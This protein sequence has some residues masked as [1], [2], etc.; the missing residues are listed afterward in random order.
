MDGTEREPQVIQA[1]LDMEDAYNQRVEHMA[2]AIYSAYGTLVDYPNDWD[3]TDG[4]ICDETKAKYRAIADD[5]LDKI[6][7]TSF[8]LVPETEAIK[9]SAEDSKRFVEALDNPPPPSE[10]LI[11]A[12]ERRKKLLGEEG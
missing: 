6:E 2:R 4:T 11:K 3:A 1:L 7:W 8:F 9:L 10:K 5:V 12:A